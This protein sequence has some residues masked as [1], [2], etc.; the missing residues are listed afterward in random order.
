VHVLVFLKYIIGVNMLG[1]RGLTTENQIDRMRQEL[2]KADEANDSDAINSIKTKKSIWRVL[3]NCLFVVICL[4][5]SM[6]LISVLTMKEN[7]KTPEVFGYRL[8]I[9]ESGSMDPTLHV[10]SV[11]LSKHPKDPSKLT[12]NDIITFE[13]SD[14]ATVTH[15]II[16]VMTDAD[17][18]VSYTT[19]GDNPINSPDV[20]PVTP[21]MISAVFVMKIPLT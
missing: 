10:G 7:G 18:S 1:R 12:E 3:G 13:R 5:L 8:Y 4:V 20:D 2:L 17:G 9:I 11:I 19:K 16:E 14:G 21:Q 6:I 15:R